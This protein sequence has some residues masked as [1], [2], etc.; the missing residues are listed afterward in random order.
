M[1]SSPCIRATAMAYAPA[2]GGSRRAPRS[3]SRWNRSDRSRYTAIARG[4]GLPASG[5]A[6]WSSSSRVRAALPF[7]TANAMGGQ[8]Q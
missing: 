2:Q 8:D 1:E 7:H 6:P 4:G 3:R 5:S